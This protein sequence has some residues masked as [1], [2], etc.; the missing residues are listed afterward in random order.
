MATNIFLI[1][2]LVSLNAFFVATGFAIVKV[3]ASQL[4][5]KVI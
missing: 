1:F 2:L 5:L 4:E 3:K